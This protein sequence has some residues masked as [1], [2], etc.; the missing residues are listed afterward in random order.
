M[1]AALKTRKERAKEPPELQQVLNRIDPSIAHLDP[2][3]K[4]VVAKGVEA[5]VRWTVT[6][7]IRLQKQRKR[8]KEF[9]VVGAVYEL[10]TG[11][12]RFLHRSPEKK[13]SKSP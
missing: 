5:N 12:V 6:E 9:T 7:L 3:G 13:N 2:K 8:E 11:R 4:D 1:T 10:K